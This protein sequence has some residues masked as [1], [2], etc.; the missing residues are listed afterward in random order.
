MFSSNPERVGLGMGLVVAKEF[1]ALHAGRL[2][3]DSRRGKGTEVMLILP[4]S[5]VVSLEPP[6]T[7][8]KRRA[9]AE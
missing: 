6:R 9:L 4:A 1:V 7:Q 5:R 3:L 8:R 2:H